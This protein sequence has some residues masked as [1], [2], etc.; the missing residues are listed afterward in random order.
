MRIVYINNDGAAMLIHEQLVSRDLPALTV[1]LPGH[2]WANIERLHRRIARACGHGWHLA[3][4]RLSEEMAEAIRRCHRDL[5][6]ALRTAEAHSTPRILPTPSEIYRDILALD[7]EFDEVEIDFDAHEL[8]VTTDAV[9]LSDIDLGRF[10]IRLDWRRLGESR[11]YRVVAR[12]PNPSATKSDVPHPHVQDETL[13][14][15][16]GRPA[17]RAA[18]TH[19][20][21]F[22]F[23]LL[24]SQV[25]HTY[26]RGSAYV[27]MDDWTGISCNDCG[28]IVSPNDSY[29]CQRCGNDLCDDCHQSCAAC[30]ES[31]CSGC[32]SCCPV[33]EENFC[34]DC[35]GVCPWRR[36]A[37]N[38]VAGLQLSG[39]R[40]AWLGTGKRRTGSAR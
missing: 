39:D 21:L 22:D 16:D 5:E 19:C 2:S 17:I 10:D 23:M 18:L 1:H 25:L 13:C 38:S 3:A 34:R 24:V 31:H 20:R 26:A 15:G 37:D 36:Y 14:E 27:E 4:R 9:V 32:L 8:C 40:D 7:A 6:T 11:P 12:D 29:C 28:T 33:C 35:M 30:E